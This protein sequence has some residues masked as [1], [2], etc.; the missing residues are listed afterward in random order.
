MGKAL[1]LLTLGM[2]VDLPVVKNCR[3]Y[4]SVHE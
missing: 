1:L 3:L 4:M 2:L